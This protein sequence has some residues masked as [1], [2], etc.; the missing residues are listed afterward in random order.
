MV[1]YINFLAFRNPTY[2][3][4]NKFYVQPFL[5]KKKTKIIKN[6]IKIIINFKKRWLII[7]GTSRGENLWK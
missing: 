3:V 7:I 6:K 5:L 2:L 4:E 1:R